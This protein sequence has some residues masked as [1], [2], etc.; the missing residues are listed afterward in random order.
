MDEKCVAYVECHDQSL[1]GDKTSLMWMLD[2]EIYSGMSVLSEETWTIHRGTLPI[3]PLLTPSLL[4]TTPPL[5]NVGISLHKLLRLITFALGGDAYLTF[6]GN[7][8]GHPGMCSSLIIANLFHNS[9]LLLINY[10][11]QNGLTFQP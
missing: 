8:F 3:L 5:L 6:F 10:F 11:F 9:R 1:V 4:N 7:E 2:A